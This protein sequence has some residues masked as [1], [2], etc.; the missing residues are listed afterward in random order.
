MVRRR[1]ARILLATGIQ[2]DALVVMALVEVT[3]TV[4]AQG[5]RSALRAVDL[6]VLATIWV[7]G[8]SD[9]SWLL[10]CDFQVSRFQGFNVSKATTLP[11]FETLKPL[12]L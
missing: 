2:F 3:E 1:R 8:H 6:D 4:A 5:G 9:S 12:K 10:G 11:D 7:A